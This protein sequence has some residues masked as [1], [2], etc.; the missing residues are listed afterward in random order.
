MADRG[1]KVTE[2][3]TFKQRGGALLLADLRCGHSREYR[4]RDGDTGRP[5]SL[6][7]GVVGV[8][9]TARSASNEDGPQIGDLFV[10]R[11]LYRLSL[12]NVPSLLREALAHIAR[13]G[14]YW[15]NSSKIVLLLSQP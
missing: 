7:T 10:A 3:W 13:A 5:P 2:V 15:S 4:G 1:K 12:I 14:A 9:R 11:S 6:L 8:G